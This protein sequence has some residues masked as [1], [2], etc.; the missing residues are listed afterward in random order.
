MA[1]V[2]TLA[3]AAVAFIGWTVWAVHRWPFGTA[4][5]GHAAIDLKAMGNFEL[6]DAA[7]DAAIPRRFR[8]LDG[9]PVAL[10]GYMYA[11]NSSDD[12]VAA[13]QFVYNVTGE[14]RSPPKAQERVFCTVL[15]GRT[16]ANPGMYTMVRVFGTFH[17][18]IHR[19]ASGK[20]DSVYR[21][22]VERVEPVS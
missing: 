5:D 14:H 16:V 12:R 13:F 22:D 3:V 9:K 2:T 18:G 20:I 6:P 21:L 1:V 15:G 17:V 11:P 8:D 10:E 4:L 19:D 7:T